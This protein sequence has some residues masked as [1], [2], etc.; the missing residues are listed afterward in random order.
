MLGGNCPVTR[1]SGKRNSESVG[2]GQVV[3]GTSELV[4]HQA[5]DVV[6]AALRLGERVLAEQALF[7]SDHSDPLPP[8]EQ[9]AVFR[10]EKHEVALALH[11]R[12]RRGCGSAS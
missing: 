4:L 5:D 11:D 1:Q 6:H 7:T 10:I 8:I 9:Q 2:K 3:A 12:G